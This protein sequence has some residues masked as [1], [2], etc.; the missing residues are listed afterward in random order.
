MAQV[1]AEY[2]AD[3]ERLRTMDRI[4]IGLLG[5]VFP[6]MSVPKSPQISG[7]RDFSSIGTC[8]TLY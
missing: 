5:A 3:L 4:D 1:R 8:P 7:F 2:Q 6:L